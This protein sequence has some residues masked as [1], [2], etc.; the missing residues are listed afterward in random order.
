[1]GIWDRKLTSKLELVMRVN[2]LGRKQED[3]WIGL[4]MGGMPSD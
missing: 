1:L 3:S 2:S 4:E